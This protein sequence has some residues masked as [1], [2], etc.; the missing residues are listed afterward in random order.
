MFSLNNG[1]IGVC[2]IDLNVSDNVR[3]KSKWYTWKR[4]SIASVRAESFETEVL[5]NPRDA[6]IVE[7]YS[8]LTYLR[9]TCHN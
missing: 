7:P 5:Y 4:S 2:R 1:F 6:S 9:H 3:I 8:S